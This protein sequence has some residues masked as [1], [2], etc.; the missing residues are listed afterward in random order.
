M[1]A[2]R[3]GIRLLDDL[4]GPDELLSLALL[5]ESLGFDALVFPHSP[6]RTNSWAL[7]AIVARETHRIELSCGGP[8][9]TT[10][11][12]EIATYVATLDQI[13]RGRVSL[14]MGAHNFETLAWIGV[15]GS[16]VVARVRE[17]SL[18][19]RR[20][21]RGER[22]AHEGHIYRWTRDAYLRFAPY[23]PAI[24]ITITAVGEPLLELSGEI[25]DGSHPMVTPPESAP[26][27]MAPIRRGLA[28]SADPDRRFDACAYVWMAISEDGDEARGLM[29]DVV[30][31]YGTFLDPRALA[32]IG[33]T[34]LDFARAHT[35][36]LARDR[37]AAR[38]A[39]SP[40]MLRT[41]IAGT[42][43][44]CVRQLRTIFDAGFD[45]V[46]IGGPIGA[47]AAAAMRLIAGRVMP[48]FR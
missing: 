32:L 43:A 37:T 35:L 45:H 26:L 5:A 2:P 20:L 22:V 12:S 18:V 24:P 6:F 47:D 39:V 17:A 33:L 36:L 48:E 41:G 13:S 9:H 38:A 40:A 23:R 14:R 46:N 3:F 30:A 16:D 28:R 11:P 44:E 31:Y 29:R 7:G 1:P 34:P 8:I 19:V 21:L 4:G 25:G 27:I 15:D 10:D 42:P